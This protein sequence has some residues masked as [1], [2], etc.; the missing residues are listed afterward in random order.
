MSLKIENFEKFRRFVTSFETTNKKGYLEKNTLVGMGY[1][2]FEVQGDLKIFKDSNIN[3]TEF[4][5]TAKHLKK[6]VS[7]FRI[8]GRCGI[9]NGSQLCQSSC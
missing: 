2:G 5:G 3:V 8:H 7:V 1:P 6:F 9:P 4:F